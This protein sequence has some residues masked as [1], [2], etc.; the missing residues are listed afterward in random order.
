MY[1]EQLLAFSNDIT[2]KV[3]FLC[4]LE[5]SCQAHILLLCLYLDPHKVTQELCAIIQ[6]SES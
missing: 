6:E 1:S 5:E 4:P 2:A 3:Y